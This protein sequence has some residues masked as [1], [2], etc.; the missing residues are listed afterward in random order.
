V[1]GTMISQALFV[2]I[3][4]YQ[5]RDERV[6]D[7]GGCVGDMEL[8]YSTLLA[9]QPDLEDRSRTLV[10]EAATTR[11]LA[12]EIERLISS[13]APGQVGFLY[14]AGHGGEVPNT[15]RTADDPEARDQI[16][17][18]HDFSRREPLLDDM[19]HAWFSR[20]PEGA[21]LAAVFDSCHSGGM[22]RAPMSMHEAEKHR[23][24]Q[25]ENRSIGF[26]PRAIYTPEELADLERL[27]RG[28]VVERSDARF[29]HLAA[30]QDDELAWERQFGDRR[31]GIFTYY[32]CQGL[33]DLGGTGTPAELMERVTAAIHAERGDQTPRLTGH[34]DFFHRGLFELE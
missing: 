9:L 29:V 1:E 22:P 2:G 33:G 32:L 17:V 16:L 20:I 12:D 34:G 10:D 6:R 13:L 23:A 3:D 5:P 4:R 11:N 8:M 30:A 26:I 24:A 21:K 19:F 7:L 25:W 15:R 14:Y 31:H 18:P 28:L 27:K